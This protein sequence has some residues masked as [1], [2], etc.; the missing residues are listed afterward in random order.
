MTMTFTSK[1]LQQKKGGM[2]FIK[3]ATLFFLWMSCILFF[4]RASFDITPNATNAIMYMAQIFLTQSGNNTSATGISLDG[5]VG[6]AFFNG[7]VGI[8]LSGPIYNLDVY[9]DT[10][11]DVVKFKNNEGE[12]Y[13][14]WPSWHGNWANNLVLKTTSNSNTIQMYWATWWVG[15]EITQRN[16][17]GGIPDYN[18]IT[19]RWGLFMGTITD[20]WVHLQTNMVDRLVINNTGDVGIGTDNPTAKLEVNGGIKIGNDTADCDENKVW[21]MKYRYDW[22]FYSYVRMCMQSGITF[23]RELIHSYCYWNQ[24]P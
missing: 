1:K 8:W 6:N 23:S 14:G 10:S 16:S 24:C 3:W 20:A 7:K 5:T 17:R 4:A 2:G 11:S 15:L 19:S 22:S 12:L 9:K 13:Y 18:S 21:T